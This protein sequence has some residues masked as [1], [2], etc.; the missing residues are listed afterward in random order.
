VMC[1]LC[2]SESFSD[3]F[4]VCSSAELVDHGYSRFCK[5]ADHD[6]FRK[7]KADGDEHFPSHH[8]PS[9]MADRARDVVQELVSSDSRYPN[10]GEKQQTLDERNDSRQKSRC[11]FDKSHNLS[12]RMFIDVRLSNIIIA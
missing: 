2:Y 1:G 4:V 5:P 10:D 3:S 12:L 6:N 11:S 7:N 9:L 8:F